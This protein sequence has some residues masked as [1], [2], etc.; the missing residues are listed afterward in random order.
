V[1]DC[2]PTSQ[3]WHGSVNSIIQVY[4]P[5]LQKTVLSVLLVIVAISGYYVPIPLNEYPGDLSLPEYSNAFN[6]MNAG[7]RPWVFAIVAWQLGALIWFS[8]DKGF[9]LVN[10]FALRVLLVTLVLAAI[11]SLT[12]S[13]GFYYWK[14]DAVPFAF[15]FLPAVSLMAYSFVLIFLGRLMDRNWPGWGF[16]ILYSGISISG[17]GL[18]FIDMVTS[19]AQQAITSRDVGVFLVL[20]LASILISV[21]TIS[22]QRHQLGTDSRPLLVTVMV[23]VFIKVVIWEQLQRFLGAE[24]ATAIFLTDYKAVLN[25]LTAAIL[26]VVLG[27]LWLKFWSNLS[28]R[29][30]LLPYAG[31]VLLSAIY[32]YQTEQLTP[33]LLGPAEF[34]FLATLGFGFAQELADIKQRLLIQKGLALK[35][36]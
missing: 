5:A 35:M 34:L 6:L 22:I 19:Y 33:P 2:F 24:A 7:T 8:R 3:I 1:I 20:T 16:W 10:A 11:G 15:V 25:A 28:V 29:S 36:P 9:P 4:K 12:A 14:Q 17:A 31:A 32:I 18:V 23:L 30:K 27:F 26:A 13:K 21:S